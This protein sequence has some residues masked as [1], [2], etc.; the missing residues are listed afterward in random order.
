MLQTTFPKECHT[1]VKEMLCI[2]TYIGKDIP[3]KFTIIPQ[4]Y[5]PMNA[6]LFFR[7]LFQNISIEATHA[8]NRHK[9]PAMRFQ[10]FC[11]ENKLSSFS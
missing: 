11:E 7:R 8:L 1:L 6:D 5:S 3:I 10:T 9:N 4:Y 2:N